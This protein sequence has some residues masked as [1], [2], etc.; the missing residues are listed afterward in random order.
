MGLPNGSNLIVKS[1]SYAYFVE[2]KTSFVELHQPIN[3]SGEKEATSVTDE[4]AIFTIRNRTTY[5]SNGNFID[6]LMEHVTGSIEATSA[7]N[8]GNVRLVKN[9]SLGGTPSYANI[10]T[11]N[12]VVEIDTSGTTVI[13]GTE[14]FSV[15][16]AGKNDALIEEL[17]QHKII[18]APGETLTLAGSSANSA[19]IRGS[20]LWRELF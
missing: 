3:A 14:V 4:V 7:N 18:I 5:E 1:S 15:P 16:L 6:I 12:S 19:T 10:N 11:T 20:G 8:L 9:A 13:G 17:I 2:G